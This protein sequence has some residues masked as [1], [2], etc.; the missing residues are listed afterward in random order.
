[1]A[2]GR[3]DKDQR[4]SDGLVPVDGLAEEGRPDD[5]S[6]NGHQVGDAAGDRRRGLIYDVEVQDVGDPRAEHAE[7][8]QRDER[9]ERRVRGEVAGGQRERQELNPGSEA[10]AGNTSC[11]TPAQ[12][13]TRPRYQCHPTRQVLAGVG[14]GECVLRVLRTIR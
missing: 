8:G 11:K 6:V 14:E 3:A 4:G 9:R 12:P 10:M 5:D 1:M 2:Y 13:R 7:S